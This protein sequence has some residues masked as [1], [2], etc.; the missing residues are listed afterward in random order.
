MI[1]PFRIVPNRR[2]PKI[3]RKLPLEYV[4]TFKT[5]ES[6]YTF[7][8]DDLASMS[9]RHY[10]KLKQDIKFLKEYGMT[11]ER[12][13]MY[14]SK[15]VEIASKGVNNEIKQG[16]ALSQILNL[17]QEFERQYNTEIDIH[18]Q[19]WLDMYCMFFILDSENELEFSESQNKKK[20]ELLKKAT[21]EE[22]ELF[23]SLV[24]KRLG[25]YKTTLVQ[26]T[27]DYIVE[28]QSNIK[29]GE[30]LKN[31]TNTIASSYTQ[32]DLQE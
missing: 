26:D 25:Y 6:I 8:D 21:E 7:S 29:Q 4:Y 27:I 18:D 13:D 23:F 24:H 20:K 3:E 2:L 9:S 22:R 15:L 30:L 11:K 16:E 12:K 10:E 32:Q 19:M 28:A 31:L 5:G 1:L 14:I 17:V